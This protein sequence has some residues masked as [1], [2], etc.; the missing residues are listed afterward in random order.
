VSNSNLNGNVNKIGK[1]YHYSFNDKLTHHTLY[2]EFLESLEK[3]LSQVKATYQYNIGEGFLPHQLEQILHN[4][5]VSEEQ[6]DRT[7][8]LIDNRS[9]STNKM[10]EVLIKKTSKKDVNGIEKLINF[11]SRGVAYLNVY[12]DDYYHGVNKSI[13]E[14]TE[15]GKYCDLAIQAI[16]KFP[17][18]F[19]QIENA[20]IENVKYSTYLD[21][22]IIAKVYGHFFGH[23]NVEE[24]LEKTGY[25]T[26]ADLFQEASLSPIITF[27]VNA[28]A[29][30]IKFTG[31]LLDFEL[32]DLNNRIEENNVD[33]PKIYLISKEAGKYILGVESQYENGIEL[34]KKAIPLYLKLKDSIPIE[35]ILLKAKMECLITEGTKRKMKI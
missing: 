30:M 27:E 26:E 4:V 20:M 29:F 11:M 5:K 33:F 14:F 31:L 1:S 6:L 19:R 8:L 32:G 22:E 10:L 16:K 28:K 15:F 21:D 34:A 35:D 23:T 7:F 17:N 12:N 18:Q 25:L 2:S 24:F 3:D 13:I 9:C